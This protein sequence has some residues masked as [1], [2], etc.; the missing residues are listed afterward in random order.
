MKQ[1]F[2]PLLILAMMLLPVACDEFE[3][4]TPSFTKPEFADQAIKAEVTA[5]GSPYTCVEMTES[6][7][8]IISEKDKIHTGNYTLGAE[9]GEYICHGFGKIK[10]AA[11]RSSE[12]RTLIITRDG[13]DPITID[14]V[15]IAPATDNPAFQNKL[16]RTWIVEKTIISAT[17]EDVPAGL[18]I[19]HA[20]P[21][22]DLPG[23]QASLATHGVE[24]DADLEGYTV[25]DV[26][27]TEAGTFLIRFT[28]Q[29][30]F[31]GDYALE[32]DGS[33]R[34]TF[35]ELTPGNEIIAGSADGLVSLDEETGRCQVSVDINVEDATYQTN[36]TWY[37]IEKK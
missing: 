12:V 11:I 10:V 23:I 17:G 36:L 2:K 22:C 26:T 32:N 30:D 16:Y 28:G 5:P 14:V 18:G 27:F 29:D 1:I 25:Q 15:F 7:L 4:A 20:E 3:T 13:Q 35:S 19:A 33:F 34:Y 37:L 8:Y 6:G 24:I 21:G 31:V 9:E